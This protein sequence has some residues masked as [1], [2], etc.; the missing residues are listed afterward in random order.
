[1]NLLDLPVDIL[2]LIFPFLDVNS[3]V[4]LTSSCKSLRASEIAEDPAFWSASTRSTFRVP[5]QPVVQHDGKRWKILYRR[6]LTQSRIYTW[7]SNAKAEL[8]HSYYSLDELLRQPPAMRRRLYSAVTNISWPTE[9]EH[10]RELGVVA[11]LQAGY[12]HF[13]SYSEW[14]TKLTDP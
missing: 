14:Q 2:F 7:G 5:N 11:D 13:V 10:Y 4:S 1:M 9:M 12:G 3:F 8:G 6:L